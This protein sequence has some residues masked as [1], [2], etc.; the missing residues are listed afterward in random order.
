MN[1]AYLYTK[2]APGRFILAR[3]HWSYGEFLHK[4]L[5][6]AY[7]SGPLAAMLIA[8]GGMSCIRETQDIPTGKYKKNGADVTRKGYAPFYYHKPGDGNDCFHFTSLRGVKAFL[9]TAEYITSHYWDGERWILE[10]YPTE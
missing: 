10:N 6:E 2:V 3:C 7:N 8:P 9:K 4:Y 1:R 5:E